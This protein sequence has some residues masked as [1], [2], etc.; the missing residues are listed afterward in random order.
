MK[1]ASYFWWVHSY[2]WWVKKKHRTS[3][4][5]SLYFWWAIVVLYVPFHLFSL[6]GVEGMNGADS[7]SRS[8]IRAYFP[9]K[10]LETLPENGQSRFLKRKE[11]AEQL[12]GELAPLVKKRLSKL[13]GRFLATAHVT[14]NFKGTGAITRC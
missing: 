9:S 2:F 3:R 11:E 12:T 13:V 10:M 14:V 7:A 8:G 4:G 5:L 6:Q 1:K